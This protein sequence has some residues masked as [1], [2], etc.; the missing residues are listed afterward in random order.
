MVY[1]GRI[2]SRQA[3]MVLLVSLVLLLL[4]SLIGLS[5][6][7]GAV[8][9][10]KITGSFWHRNQSLQSAEG[11]LRL[12]EQVV[13]RTGTALP[14]C[15]SSITCAPPDEAFS[16][17]GAGTNPSSAVTWVAVKGALYGI[18]SLGP[19]IGLANLPPQ[20]PAALYR[21]TA[22]GLSGQ[23]RTVLETVYARVEEGG[24]SWFQR[25]AWR[26]LQ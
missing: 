25:V 1:A 5:S 23:S 19:G 7:Q 22:V 9:Q 14:K 26:Q 2:F 15:S 20:T 18:Q 13:Q 12:G 24:I 16:V 6:I 3:G 17:I 8:A 4:L 11:G 10:Q 21:V